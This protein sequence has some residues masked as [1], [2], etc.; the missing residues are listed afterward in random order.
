MNPMLSV[1][2]SNYGGSITFV[3]KYVKQAL[4]RIE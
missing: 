1:G 2:S 3:T 4:E